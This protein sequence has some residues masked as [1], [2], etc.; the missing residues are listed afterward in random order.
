MPNSSK[1]YLSQV[2]A[3]DD[4]SLDLTV[5]LKFRSPAPESFLGY[6]GFRV[7]SFAAGSWVWSTGGLV[8]RSGV[9]QSVSVSAIRTSRLLR[10]KTSLSGFGFRDK[11]V[12]KSWFA[13][14]RNGNTRGATHPRRRRFFPTAALLRRCCKI[15][16]MPHSTG[17]KSKYRHWVCPSQ[18]QQ[19]S[20]CATMTSAFD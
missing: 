14:V 5:S 20:S 1:A 16:D 8:F 15:C 7:S 4:P 18:L 6:R 12:G 13:C 3:F 2:S 11:A 17:S 9:R 19:G 10:V